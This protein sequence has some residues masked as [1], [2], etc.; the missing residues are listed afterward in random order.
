MTRSGSISTA[1]LAAL[2][3][4]S[5]STIHDVLRRDGHW[6]GVV[7]LRAGLATERQRNLRWPLADLRAVG[8]AA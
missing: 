4:V 3:G 8:I 7:P 5:A 6:C 1:E 2:A